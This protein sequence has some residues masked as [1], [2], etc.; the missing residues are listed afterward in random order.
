MARYKVSLS[1]LRHC[2]QPL[3]ARL[4]LMLYWCSFMHRWL[5][6]GSMTVTICWSKLSSIITGMCRHLQH[7]T[8]ASCKQVSYQLAAPCSASPGQAHLAT[9]FWYLS[10]LAE[11][12]HHSNVTMYMDASETLCSCEANLGRVPAARAQPLTQTASLCRQAGRCSC[13]SGRLP[14]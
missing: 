2:T 9:A 3:P 7:H 6:A 1:V 8:A 4:T 11:L 5:L 13:S 14:A 12:F 10:T